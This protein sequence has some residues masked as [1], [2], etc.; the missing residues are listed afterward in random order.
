M[1][2][3]AV[4]LS[5]CGFLDGSEVTESI[6]LLIQ[7]SQSGVEYDCYSLEQSAALTSHSNSEN[8]LSSQQDLMEMSSRITRGKTSPLLNLDPS[9]Y[10]GLA[11]PGGY[12]VAKHFSTWATQGSNCTVNPLIQKT[13]QDFHSQS[14][15]ILAICIAPAILAKSL[16]SFD[17]DLTLTI[18]NDPDTISEIEK[19]GANHELC[20]ATDF[21]TDRINKIITTPA[22]MYEAKPHEVFLGIQKAC[23]EFIEMS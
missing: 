1:K 6:S 5:G 15:P 10:D 18:G 21:V 11:I 8:A 3:I 2:K 19:T 4:L 12:G 7:L 14:K 20:S 16:E 17:K 13:I 9:K 23:N 22:Y